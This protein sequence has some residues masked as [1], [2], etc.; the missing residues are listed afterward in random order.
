MKSVKSAVIAAGGF[1]SRLFPATKSIAKPLIPILNKP[2]IHYI[3][4]DCIQAGIE[5]IIIVKNPDDTSIENYF[6]RDPELENYLHQKGKV[7]ILNDF[8]QILDRCDFEFIPEDKSL[9]YGNARA[10]CTVK[11]HLLN[12]PFVYMWSDV[13]YT[14][15][16]STVQEAIKKFSEQSNT[17]GVLCASRVSEAEIPKKGIVKI[18]PGTS[19]EIEFIIEKPKLEEAPSNIGTSAPYVFSPEIFNYLD[20]HNVNARLGELVVQDAISQMIENGL[21]F[22]ISFASGK[23]L[24]NG[25]PFNMFKSTVEVALT[26][27]D[28]GQRAKEYLEQINQTDS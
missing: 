18:K 10:L 9:P 8:Y 26:D 12:M 16:K 15:T 28:I 25:D 27:P 22:K 24:T 7:G 4:E 21:K 6:S 23:Y 20:P 5:K 11:D 1:G 2:T 13:F 17:H 19:D 14:G 3:L